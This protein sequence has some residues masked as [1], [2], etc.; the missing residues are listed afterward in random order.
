[1]N[2][3]LKEIATVAAATLLAGMIQP[4]LPNTITDIEFLSILNHPYTQFG[5]ITI[6]GYAAMSWIGDVIQRHRRKKQYRA[7]S[8]G[9]GGKSAPD[10]DVSEWIVDRFGVKWRVLHGRRGITGKPYAYTDSA[11]CPKCGTDLMT[12]TKYR[13]IRRDKPIWK[14]A[15]CGFTE[16]RPSKFLNEEDQAVERMVERDARNKSP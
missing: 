1:M 2:T 12:D 15:G 16:G 9:L 13:M 4:V 8:M 7:M 5:L 10:R 14:C 11:V 6:V 3:P